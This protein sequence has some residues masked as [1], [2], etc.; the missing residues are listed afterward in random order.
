VEIFVDFMLFS[1]DLNSVERAKERVGERFA[2][3]YLE[4]VR[5][6]LFFEVGDFSR[7]P[8]FHA[9]PTKTCFFSTLAFFSS[10]NPIFGR[11]LP[12]IHFFTIFR[13]F[14]GPNQAALRSDVFSAADACRILATT[15]RLWANTAQAT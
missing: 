3:I 4:P 10:K 12:L 15:R 5:K 14:F 9:S 8:F 7:P 13:C 11:G 6:V 2:A 1:G